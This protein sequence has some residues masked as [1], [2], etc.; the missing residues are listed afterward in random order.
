[1]KKDE[2]LNIVKDLCTNLGVVMGVVAEEDEYIYIEIKEREKL[3]R[4]SKI[5]L[6]SQHLTYAKSELKE[7]VYNKLQ[8]AV[9]AG[10][11]GLK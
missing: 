3:R 11:K 4:I 1:M 6:S 9:R 7:I 2:A 5:T 10:L 8:D